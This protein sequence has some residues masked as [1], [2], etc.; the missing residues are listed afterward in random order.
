MKNKNLGRLGTD[1]VTG[2]TGTIVGYVEYLTGCNQYLIVPKCKKGEEHSKPSGEWIDDS[3]I[4]ISE[5]KKMLK[6]VPT[7]STGADITPAKRG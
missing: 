4:E 1:I 7:E 3:R 2:F 5:T 6:L